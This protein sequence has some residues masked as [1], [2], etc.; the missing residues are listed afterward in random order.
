MYIIIPPKNTIPIK[1]KV[2]DDLLIIFSLCP[3]DKIITLTF[4]LF[5]FVALY[6]T[7]PDVSPIFS[8]ALL[9]PNAAA[10]CTTIPQAIPPTPPSGALNAVNTTEHIAVAPDSIEALNIAGTNKPP[11]NLPISV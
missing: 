11:E 4:P 8:P 10:A 1:L 6:I 2:I 9:T 3:I 7:S 5:Y